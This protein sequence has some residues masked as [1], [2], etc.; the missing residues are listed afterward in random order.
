MRTEGHHEHPKPYPVN[1]LKPIVLFALMIVLGISFHNFSF[2][3]EDDGKSCLDLP[4]KL[5]SKIKE[6]GRAEDAAKLDAAF[7]PASWE[8]LG[9]PLIDEKLSLALQHQMHVLDNGK[10]K[11]GQPMGNLEP[12]FGEFKETIRILLERAGTHPTDLHHFFDAY[13]VW[14]DDKKGNVYFTG[15]F[16]PALKVRKTPNGK[17]KYP[18]YAFPEEWEG[19]IPSRREIDH[20][21]ALQGKGLELAFASNPF[22]VYVMQLQGSGTVEFI[23]TGERMLFKY[24]GEN[25]HPYRNIQRFFTKRAKLANGNL[26]LEG[27][28]RYLLKNPEMTDSVLF[29]NPSYTFFTPKK[30]LAKGAA[31]VPLISGVSIA[32]DPKYF[33]LGSV[34]LAAMPVME[35]GKVTHHEYKILLP[36]DVGG[37]IK[38]AGRVDVYCGNGDLGMAKASS[39]HHYG[40]MWVLLPKKNEQMALND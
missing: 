23:E 15:Y 13:Q 26:S 31:D 35:S 21:K 29:Y 39:L 11:D 12:T 22:D 3:T 6:D 37:V 36:Q 16:T 34:L 17:Y 27:I 14:G 8:A 30:G 32:A 40:K 4:T 33:P 5:F 38:G 9:F 7:T 2:T 28:R 24:A 25:G 10:F 18:L 20:N 19:T 1:K